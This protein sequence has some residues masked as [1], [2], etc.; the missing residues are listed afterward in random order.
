MCCKLVKGTL[1]STL[2]P[3]LLLPHSTLLT[4]LCP[5]GRL[6]KEGIERK[7]AISRDIKAGHGQR[8]QRLLCINL[9]RALQRREGAK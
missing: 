9:V 6:A 5:A 7:P 2:L 3:S 4:R 1:I 8:R